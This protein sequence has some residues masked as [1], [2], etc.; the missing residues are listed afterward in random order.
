MSLTDRER[1]ILARLAA[2]QSKPT[3][4]AELWVTPNTIKTQTAAAYRKL[5][6]HTS[7]QAVAV[8]MR[9]GVIE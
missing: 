1:D 2:G 9:A 6:V 4:A 8:A 5:G 7:A 3:M